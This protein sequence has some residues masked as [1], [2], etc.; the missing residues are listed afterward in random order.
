MAALLRNCSLDWDD[1]LREAGRSH[2]WRP[3]AVGLELAAGLFQAPVPPEVWSRVKHDRAAAGIAAHL[4]SKLRR[5]AATFEDAPSGVLLH[6]RMI[7]GG[8]GKLRYLWHRA[9]E[10]KQTDVNFVQLPPTIS[11]AYY[12]IRP[13]RVACAALGRL[14]R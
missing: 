5:G 14:R 11:A 9:V 2:C 7:E 3:V 6:L 10:P 4:L 13:F 8:S 1:V 12:L